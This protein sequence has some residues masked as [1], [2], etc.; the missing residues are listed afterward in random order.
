MHTSTPSIYSLAQKLG[1]V[2]ELL[3]SHPGGENYLKR[4]KGIRW[5]EFEATMEFGQG[6]EPTQ[7]NHFQIYLV[8]KLGPYKHIYA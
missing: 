8:N 5:P 7:Y 6:T 1:R 3:F 4:M 2:K